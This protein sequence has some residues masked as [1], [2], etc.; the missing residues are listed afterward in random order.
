MADEPLM[1][2]GDPVRLTQVFANLLN[3]AAKYTDPGGRIDVVRD[4]SRARPVVVTVRDTGI[5]IDPEHL[6]SVFDMFTQVIAVGPP[7][8]GRARH[9]PDAGAQPGGA[10]RRVGRRRRATGRAAAA[11]SRCGCR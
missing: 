1:V 3:N 5:G 11:S 10:A 8:P 7:H 2:D 4:A 9:R 6:S